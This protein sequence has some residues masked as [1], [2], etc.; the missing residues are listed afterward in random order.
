[1]KEA[2]KRGTDGDSQHAQ[3]I[4]AGAIAE[5]AAGTHYMS[6]A[7]CFGPSRGDLGATAVRFVLAEGGIQNETNTSFLEYGFDVDAIG[8]LANETKAL[9][10]EEHESCCHGLLF[11]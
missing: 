2:A 10:A 3:P 7:N 11:V 5:S 9:T 6:E 1:M 4:G 8:K